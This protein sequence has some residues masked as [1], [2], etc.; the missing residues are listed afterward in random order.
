SSH[1]WIAL[2]LVVSLPL[3]PAAGSWGQNTMG[4]GAAFSFQEQAI[5]PR[6]ACPREAVPEGGLHA[7][8]N[9]A[10]HN[11]LERSLQ[12]LPLTLQTHIGR[13]GIS[14][15]K[16]SRGLLISCDGP[17]GGRKTTLQRA[18]A[19]DH[20]GSENDVYIDLDELLKPPP[21]RNGIKK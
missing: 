12:P 20:S 1:R 18:L 13:H 5:V 7:K 16:P 10:A 3:D 17:S 8:V 14:S 4:P 15:K 11:E 21:Y 19:D 6:L 9:L 2:S